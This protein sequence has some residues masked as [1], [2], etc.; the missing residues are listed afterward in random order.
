MVVGATVAAHRK[1]GV[2]CC[3]RHWI[4]LGVQ[5]IVKLANRREGM[6]VGHRHR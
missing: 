2:G 6:P 4:F 5:Y 3:R 1:N